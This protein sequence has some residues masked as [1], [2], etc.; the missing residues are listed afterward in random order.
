MNSASTVSDTP[1][2]SSEKAKS[3]VLD[4]TSQRI[5]TDIV[6]AEIAIK[7]LSVNCAEAIGVFTHLRK[8]DRSRFSSLWE[9][10]KERLFESQRKIFELA[11]FYKRS[12]VAVTDEKT[13]SD[14]ATV[15]VGMLLSA[16]ITSE[17]DFDT[18]RPLRFA[19][20]ALLIQTWENHPKGD[21]SPSGA[22]ARIV[23]AK[24]NGLLDAQV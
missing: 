17:S 21:V 4:V 7:Q 10:S 1:A 5:L 11:Q 15:L 14:Y 16:E 3:L 24:T 19:K 23:A 6:A 2:D 13:G 22:I 20:F 8:Y 12:I 18:E 9:S